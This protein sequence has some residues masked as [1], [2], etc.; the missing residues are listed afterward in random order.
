MFW[1]WR[2]HGGAL[3]RHGGGA[4]QNGLFL[5]TASNAN[6]WAELTLL[7]MWLDCGKRVIRTILN[8]GSRASFEP[9]HGLELPNHGIIYGMDMRWAINSWRT[10]LK[11]T[12]AIIWVTYWNSNGLGFWRVPLNTRNSFPIL[13][14]IS[15]HKKV[16]TLRAF[17][18]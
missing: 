13:R 14:N 3:R 9:Y 15:F 10:G 18:S 8:A 17:R 6:C 2:N 12:K 5:T 16:G 1:M 11:S 4:W 7:T